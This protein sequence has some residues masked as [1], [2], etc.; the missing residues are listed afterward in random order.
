MA[1]L[2]LLIPCLHEEPAIGHLV[3]DCWSVTS[4]IKQTEIYFYTINNAHQTLTAA[5]AAGAITKITA[6]S[7]TPDQLVG[8]MLT[9]IDADCYIILSPAVAPAQ[10][11]LIPALL[12]LVTRHQLACAYPAIALGKLTHQ[13][14]PQISQGTWALSRSLV[15]LW[16]NQAATRDLG[17][18]LRFLARENQLELASLPAGLPSQMHVRPPARRQILRQLWSLHRRY[19]PYRFFRLLALLCLV[20]AASVFFPTVLCKQAFNG[21]LPLLNCS[22]LLSL[23]A[24]SLAYGVWQEIHQRHRW[25]QN[26]LIAN[27]K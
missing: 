6:T 9:E 18:E 15:K 14:W 5:K 10:I 8:Q 23:A 25:G 26:N 2:A 21:P 4:G 27:K 3:R 17:L 11:A 1:H 12:T 24:L 20:M 22:S 13:F 7:T 16:T 19:H